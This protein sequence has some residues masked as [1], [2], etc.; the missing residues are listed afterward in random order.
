MNTHHTH[1]HK[2]H[3]H[4]YTHVCSLCVLSRQ[5][6]DVW[7]GHRANIQKIDREVGLN[8]WPHPA[9]FFNIP[10]TNGCDDKTIRIYTDGS[11]GERGV[12]AG[13]VIFVNNELK[14]R[15]KFRLN[16]RCCNNRA[17]QLAIVKA[18]DLINYLEIADNK[19]RTI[20]V[21]TDSRITIDSL[22]NASN[23]NYLFEEI[24]NR[25]M[26]LRSAKWTIEF[27]WIKA[28]AGNLGNELTDRL[29]KDAA[30]DKDI[31]FVFD[32]IP[33]TTLYSELEEEATL[34]W[35]EERERCNKAAV[36]KQFFPKVRDRINRRITIN[37]NITAL[38]MVKPSPTSTY[39]K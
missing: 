37:P 14:A 32:R 1:T 23:H 25:L 36:T 5:R 7:K 27:S 24:R 26:N 29:A 8:H 15:H 10:E 22:K 3:T 9:D 13:V 35:Q 18:L 16:N 6:Y 11:K 39:L 20:G 12:G 34:K 17:K 31:P 2:H 38:V 4:T 21:Y 30:S 28:H 19:P 33:K